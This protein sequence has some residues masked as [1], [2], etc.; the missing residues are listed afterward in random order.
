MLKEQKEALNTAVSQEDFNL[1]LSKV[2]KSVS[3][4]DL[5]RFSEWMS[6]FGSA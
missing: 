6:E 2:N 3:D 5:K 1:A 4:N